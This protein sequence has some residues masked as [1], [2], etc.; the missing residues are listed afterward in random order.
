M[1]ERG[2]SQVGAKKIDL[3]VQIFMAAK[4]MLSESMLSEQLCN[5]GLL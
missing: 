3:Q 1:H 2:N 5:V 4:L